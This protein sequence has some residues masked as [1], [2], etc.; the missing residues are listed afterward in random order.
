MHASLPSPAQRRAAALRLGFDRLAAPA[1]DPAA[2][3]ALARDV[4]GD[5]PADPDGA[6][7]ASAT[8]P[9]PR[10]LQGRTTFLDRVVVNA[11][12]R[13][14][15]QVVVAGPGYDG[16]A[17]RY[18]KPGVRWWEV[19][20]A[21]V[22]A[23]KRD[24]LGRL[25]IDTSRVT[26]VARDLDARGLP[27]A[28]L[29]TGFEP[30]APA[31][32]ICEAGTQ[33][34]SRAGL[35]ALLS[36]LR[37]L[38]TP[39]TRLAICASPGGALDDGELDGAALGGGLAGLLAGSRWR[40]V[41]M[42]ERAQR[43]GFAVAAPVFAPAPAAGAGPPSVGRIAQFAERMLH[44][45][46]TATLGAHL[47]SGYG[48][49]VAG[50]RELDLGVHR[51]DLAGGRT[52]IGRVFPAARAES[53]AQDDARLLEWLA[54]SGFPAERTAA[55]NPVSVH[56]AQAVLVTEFATGRVLPSKPESFEL[57]GRLLGRLHSL[58]ADLAPVRRPGGA[59]HHLLLGGSPADE[60]AALAALLSDAR[61]RVPDG[62]GHRY[63]ALVTAVR[64][65]DGCADLPH[66]F[67][68]P[69]L[70]PRNV[71]R[72]PPGEAVVIDWAGSGWGPRVVSLGCLLWAAT[73]KPGI[74]AALH[75][76]REFVTLEPAETERL[77]A[78]MRLRPLVLACWTFATGRDTLRSRADWWDQQRR[79]VD[80]I[81]SQARTILRS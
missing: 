54:A 15:A 19:D 8:A 48:V 38:S 41:D 22:Q 13:Q 34:L 58:Q 59:W 23:D 75:G 28:L 63:D 78:A 16:R 50:L 26:F 27:A 71:I 62:D 80:T 46:G 11:L 24:R 2:D 25:G 73:G 14:I 55:A 57:L 10:Y 29:A 52:W 40:P 1:G 79:R 12:N 31:L 44:R 36:D 76:Y 47:E 70:V 49:R 77:D 74:A 72:S 5:Q 18:G 51:V 6:A 69:D 60:V 66:A 81:A 43:A 56:E 3:E 61:P 20:P 37:S 32:F 67:V 17:L 68:H 42:P 35:S 7:A 53:A 21:A 64:S 4:A 33:G 65:V 30:D 45:A 39:G 9:S